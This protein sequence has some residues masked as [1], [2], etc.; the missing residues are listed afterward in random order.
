MVEQ[1]L[2][3]VLVTDWGLAL[4][5]VGGLVLALVLV[6]VLVLGGEWRLVFVLPSWLLSLSLPLPRAA[7][8][9]SW[10]TIRGFA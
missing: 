10:L 6:L 1:C 2:A 3:L 9:W 5:F 7:V 8:V 4:V